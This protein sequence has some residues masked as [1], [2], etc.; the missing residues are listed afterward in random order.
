[1]IAAHTCDDEAEDAGFDEAGEDVHS[2]EYVPGLGE[3]GAAGEAEII[4]GDDVAAEHADDVTDQNKKREHEG[5]GNDAGG[6]E[7]F[8]WVYREGF[9]G[10]DLFGDAHGADFC[11]DGG[12]DATGDHKA[13]EDRGKSW[14]RICFG[15]KG[16]VKQ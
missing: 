8:E 9:E 5:S 14:R 15:K 13:G 7:I 4:D 12:T 2:F 6:Y 10:V 3:V 11:G 16:G 1:V